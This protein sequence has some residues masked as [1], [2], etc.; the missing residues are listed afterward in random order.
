M[1]NKIMICVSIIVVLFTIG[2]LSHKP[3]EEKKMDKLNKLEA[4]ILNINDKEITV[5]DSNNIIYTF[6][7]NDLK[8]NIGDYIVIEYTGI[9]DK[10]NPYQKSVINSYKVKKFASKKIPKDYLSDGIFKEYYTLAY[11]KLQ[12]LSLDEKIAQLLL[13]R[14]PEKDQNN[15]LK[16]YQFGGYIFFAKDFINKSKN[17]TIQMIESA[18]EIAK[19]P[20]LT[21]VDE[22]GGSVV[23][24]S[25]NPQLRATK[26][27]SPRSLYQAGGMESIVNDTIEKSNLLDELGLNLNLAPVVDVSTDPS[28]YMYDRSLGENAEVTAE[29]AKTVI[30]TSKKGKVSYTLKHFPGYGNNKDTHKDTVVDERTLEEIRTHDLPP[31]QSGIDAGAE[32]VLISHNIV[33]NIDPD[34]PASLSQ[35]VHNLLRDE[36]NFTGIIITDDLAMGA[37]SKIENS[38]EKAILAGNDLLI[39][40]NYEESFNQLKNSVKEGR[41]SEAQINKLVFRILA[42]K[43]YKGL[44]FNNTK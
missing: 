27:L 23:R 13:V 28:D 25:S 14:Y 7:S 21:A 36:L 26:F 20:I 2:I 18:Q 15:I 22:E 40:T 24:V 17:E 33:N 29:F 39:V 1:K 6:S 38:V 11:N 44:M 3:P 4:I 31:F 37:T 16:Q 32:A 41:I 35:S 5:Q 10:L 9:L 34:N 42:W 8:A 30:T 12:E 19:I 43:Y